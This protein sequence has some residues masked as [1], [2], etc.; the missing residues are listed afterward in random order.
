MFVTGV[1][2]L[3]A[4]LDQGSLRASQKTPREPKRVAIDTLKEKLYL[5]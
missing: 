4:L 2:F 1:S 3:T 5:H